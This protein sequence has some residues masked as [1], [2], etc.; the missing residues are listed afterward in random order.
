LKLA[1]VGVCCALASLHAADAPA[2]RAAPK[3][4]TLS[5]VTDQVPFLAAAFSQVFRDTLAFTAAAELQLPAAEGEVPAAIPFVVTMLD[6]RMRFDL[7]LSATNRA[8][9]P[10]EQIGAFRDLGLDRLTVLMQQDK[11]VI[12]SFPSLKAY[13][14]MPPPKAPAGVQEQAQLKAGA[15][16]RRAAGSEVVDGRVCDKF[17]IT[18]ANDRERKEQATVWEARDL[19]RL[20]VK[21]R[22]QAQNGDIY[23][24]R[25]KAVRMQRSD[26]RLFDAPAGFTKH[27]SLDSLVQAATMRIIG[28]PPK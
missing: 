19:A 13:L 18:L 10:V 4:R 28:A 7:Q 21:L 16:E 1:A 26:P 3:P 14:A 5:S 20:P 11:D 17:L 8:G 2:Q 9:L 24:L 15:L 6:G 12:L 27:A 22:V 25:F 23:G